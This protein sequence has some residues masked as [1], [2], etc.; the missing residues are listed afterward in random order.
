MA[1]ADARRWSGQIA[2]PGGKCLPQ[3][4][5]VAAA[6][7]ET[8]EEAGLDLTADDF[9]LLGELPRRFA[10]RGLAMSSFV[11]L[12]VCNPEQGQQ[13]RPDPLEVAAAW[14][15]P[16][17]V[18]ATRS[19]VRT[20]CLE[21]ASSRELPS[22]LTT[23]LRLMGVDHMLFP[24]LALPPPPRDLTT[25]HLDTL[26]TVLWGLTLGIV[27]DL[28]H[29]GKIEAAG[30]LSPT[31]PG[32]PRG[33]SVG[34]WDGKR[35]AFAS[36]LLPLLL[37]PFASRVLHSRSGPMGYDSGRAFWLAGAT[38]VVSLGVLAGMAAARQGLI[39]PQ[40]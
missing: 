35:S 16:L 15:V 9:V 11:F 10:R 25:V 26:Q 6:Q 40:L 31:I 3:E 18:L 1:S 36:S 39:H 24:C 34:T 30:G 21:L 37:W 33:F 7:R 28:T 14:W 23:G 5:N 8:L 32:E 12:Q 38:M 20:L 22:V 19:E 13:L 29:A 4:T 27:S 17:S 2:F